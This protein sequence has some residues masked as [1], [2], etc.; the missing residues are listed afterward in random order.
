MVTKQDRCIAFPNI[1]QHKVSPF[2]LQDPTKPG[3]RKII[4]LF[5]CDPEM[6]VI[7]TTSNI[8][9]QQ[10]EWYEN[11]LYTVPDQSLVATLPPE[12]R[13]MIAD[14]GDAGMTLDE[15]KE[16][17][18][19][20]MKERTAFVKKNDKGYFSPEFSMCEQ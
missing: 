6:E 10:R 17:R 14:A 11:A 20:L 9:P 8:P 1:Y 13:Q 19:K 3:H 2:K 7:P 15:A 4:A 18:L 16:H 5:L 12:V